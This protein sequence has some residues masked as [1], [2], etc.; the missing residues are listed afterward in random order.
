[1]IHLPSGLRKV[2]AKNLGLAEP[3]IPFAFPFGLFNN[4]VVDGH[5]IYVNADREN[6]IHE[7]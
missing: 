4:V 7:F 2:V 6:V 3:V 5:D 1:M